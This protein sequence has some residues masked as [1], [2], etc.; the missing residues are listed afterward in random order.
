MTGLRRYLS[1]NLR[2][3]KVSSPNDIFRPFCQPFLCTLRKNIFS[4]HPLH[5]L[6][7]FVPPVYGLFRRKF[8]PSTQRT[9][10]TILATHFHG[11]RAENFSLPPNAFFRPFLGGVF[12]CC[13]EFIFSVRL[14]ILPPAGF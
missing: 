1:K 8:S 2:R 10:E 14:M 7:H 6:R 13:G 9:F 3:E 5:F 11:F 4:L 12:V